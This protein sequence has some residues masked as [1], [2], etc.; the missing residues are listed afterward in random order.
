M[1]FDLPY[2][3]GWSKIGKI[4][5]HQVNQSN[6]LENRHW[7]DFDYRIGTKAVLIKDGIYHKA[8]DHNDGPYL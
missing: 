8:G 3:T 6:I 7:I 4:R 2:I 1:L 5:Q